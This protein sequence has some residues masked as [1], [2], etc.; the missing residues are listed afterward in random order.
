MKTTIFTT[1]LLATLS[2]AT[3]LKRQS[4]CIVQTVM[5]PNSNQAKASIQQW[6]NDVKNVN[7]FL[8]AV[9]NLINDEDALLSEARMALTNAMDEPCQLMTLASQ[10]AFI[11]APVPA[12]DCA[13][14]DL[15]DVFEVH[16]LQNLMAVIADPGNAE[17]AQASVDD[18][19]AFRCCN[20]LPDVDILFINS[21]ESEGIANQVP[22][23]VGRED[24]CA[25]I[26]CTKKCKAKQ[27]ANGT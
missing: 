22:L 19:N 11:Q 12:F 13:V 17:V 23:S 10:S 24:A 14:E 4:G 2:A 1:S 7:A 16:V 9:P 25:D 6:N 3:P 26:Q 15:M 8:N 18:I 21:A 20:V 5:N 27:G